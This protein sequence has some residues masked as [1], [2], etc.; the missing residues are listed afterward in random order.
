MRAIGH[1]LP[2]LRGVKQGPEHPATLLDTLLSHQSDSARLKSAHAVRDHFTTADDEGKRAFLQLLASGYNTD[3]KLLDAAI[4]HYRKQRD[5][6]SLSM[7]HAA[8]EPRRQ[9]ILRR[10]NEL[11]GGTASIID[12]RREALRLKQDIPDFAAL[13]HCFVHLLAS[14]FNPGFLEL[15]QLDFQSSADLASKLI[16]YEAVHAIDSWQSL[17]SRLEPA[18]RRCYA[19]FHPRLGDEPLIFLELALTLDIPDSIEDILRSDREVIDA[20]DATTA[21]FYSIS[22]CQQG[23]RG[24]PFG[25]LL[26]K[27]VV[28]LLRA[29]CRSLKTFVTLSPI[30]GLARW[31]GETGGG[32]FQPMTD[33]QDNALIASASR[34]TLLSRAAQYLAATTP[35]HGDPVA[36]FHLGN[37]ASIE[38]LNWMADLS[39]QGLRQSYGLM[40]NYRYD[41]DHIDYDHR[42]FAE[43]ALPRMSS[44]VRLL[45]GLSRQQSGKRQQNG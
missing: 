25:G 36:R 9:T 39:V 37:G 32:A 20:C 1:F 14:W 40:V 35:D 28:D 45:A 7:L 4:S 41:L 10:L 5:P 6:L 33:G 13:D 22:N 15:R 34:Q 11:P 27:R 3:G 21:V 19:F 29:E 12:M 38:R 23:L 18:D 42:A 31:L 24:I 16:Q 26:I 2:H 8:S 17:R 44:E 43:G 30:P